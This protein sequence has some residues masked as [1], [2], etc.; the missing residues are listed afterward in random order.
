MFYEFHV[1]CSRVNGV[2]FQG[3]PVFSAISKN[4]ITVNT[5]AFQPQQQQQQPQ[6]AVPQAGAVPVY[7]QPTAVQPEATIYPGGPPPQQ[8]PQAQQ[9]M[10]VM[11]PN[12]AKVGSTI[13]W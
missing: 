5:D 8:Q 10:A 13:Q 6:Y 3:C 4:S 2:Y 11:I 9:M 1:T 12:D 7:A